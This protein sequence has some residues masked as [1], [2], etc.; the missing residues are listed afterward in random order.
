MVQA[1][2]RNQEHLHPVI[3]EITETMIARQSTAVQAYR[4]LQAKALCSRQ[5]EKTLASRLVWHRCNGSPYGSNT[6][7]CRGSTRGPHRN[8]Q[9][10][11]R[12]VTFRQCPWSMFQLVRVLIPCRNSKASLT[13]K[14][15]YPSVL[16]VLAAVEWMKRLWSSSLSPSE[17]RKGEDW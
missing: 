11:R 3:K 6:L 10:A 7:D 12:I 8:K 4:D 15:Y 9:P 5:A 14:M 1:N 2:L 16:P 13:Q 17:G